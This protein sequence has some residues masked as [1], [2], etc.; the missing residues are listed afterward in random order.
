MGGGG[1]IGCV[2]DRVAGYLKSIA[3]RIVP[4]AHVAVGG[5]KNAFATAIVAE[6]VARGLQVFGGGVVAQI[7][8]QSGQINRVIVGA[9]CFQRKLQRGVVQVEFV[10]RLIIGIVE[11]GGKVNVG[12]RI[13]GPTPSP[14]T[15]RTATIV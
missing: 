4:N 9:I 7:I 1:K 12:I 8:L 15:L 3:R 2:V 5:H 6:P 11:V 10:D 14:T 13:V